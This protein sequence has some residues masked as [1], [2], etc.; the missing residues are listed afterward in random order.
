MEKIMIEQGYLI[1]LGPLQQKFFAI[2]DKIDDPIDFSLVL[3]PYL[4]HVNNRSLYSFYYL[5][6]NSKNNTN[7]NHLKTEAY[8]LIKDCQSNERVYD[9]IKELIHRFF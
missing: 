2:I 3:K 4:A 5:L 7:K 8:W 9:L 6:N 1:D